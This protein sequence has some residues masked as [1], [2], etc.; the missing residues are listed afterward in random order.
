[1]ALVGVNREWCLNQGF[2]RCSGDLIVDGSRLHPASRGGLRPVG[3]EYGR[4]GTDGERVGVAG[5][6]WQAMRQACMYRFLF[7]VV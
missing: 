5:G 1:M 2:S 6:E 4:F 7:E 3:F